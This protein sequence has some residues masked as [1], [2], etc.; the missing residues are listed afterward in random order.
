[1]TK[2]AV[3]GTI[4]RTRY[5]DGEFLRAF[6]FDDEQSY[7][8]EMRRRMNRYLHLYG[9][10]QGLNLV[11]DSE[12]GVTQVSIMPGL[13]IDAYGREIYVFAP[14]T[15]G[16]LDITTNRITTATTYDVWIRYQKTAATPPS[17]GYSACNQANQYTRWV[18]S[19]SVELLKSPAAPF[20]DP[21]FSDDDD[22]DPSQDQV[23]VLL[24][25]VYIQPTSP[26]ATFSDPLFDSQRCA[27]VGVIAQRIQTPPGWDA[28]NP[29]SPQFAPFNFLN[30]A[31]NTP[32]SPPVSLEIMPNI[33]ADQNLIVGPDFPLS[34]P[35]TIVVTPPAI[36][37]ATSS[38]KIAGDLFVQGNI[39]S[40]STP[41][42]GITNWNATSQTVAQLVQS[43]MPDFVSFSTPQIMVPAPPTSATSF[44]PTPPYAFTISSSKI[45]SISNATAVVSIDGI[46]YN[47]GAPFGTASVGVIVTNVS[48]APATPSANQ[49]T[50]SVTYTVTGVY[51]VGV[52]PTSPVL[53]F[54]LSALVVCYPP[55]T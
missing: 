4:D 17:S 27:L 23:A 48:V 18:E 50:I 53:S 11:A 54:S 21:G 31:A 37:P 39:Y 7:H 40:P 14:Y 1:V 30:S 55:S 10:V 20:T 26:T 5:Y 51:L 25:T 28:S 8:M 42:P 15:L 49:V 6:D 36:N 13:A 38:V 2:E 22:D 35:P 33:F 29:P 9:I 3:V 52:T 41:S 16:N 19:F 45:S 12:G 32:L 44:T 24:G 43:M 34:P 46:Q 47:P